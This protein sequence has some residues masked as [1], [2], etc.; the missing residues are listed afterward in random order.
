MDANGHEFGSG[1]VRIR[2][3]SWLAEGKT[4]LAEGKTVPAEG[5]IVGFEGSWAY[6]WCAMVK[7]G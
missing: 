5:R 1:F 2:V 4:V 7:A 6:S 3:D